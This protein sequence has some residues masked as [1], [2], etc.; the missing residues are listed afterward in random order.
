MH[1]N[2]CH[3]SRAPVYCHGEA[4]C[5]KILK[6]L[7]WHQAQP[8]HVSRASHLA[9]LVAGLYFLDGTIFLACL[10]LKS[11]QNFHEKPLKKVPCHPAQYSLALKD[12]FFLRA[13][14]RLQKKPLKRAP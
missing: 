1:Q 5:L 14:S 2:L 3:E 12:T 4:H 9:S 10:P 13:R 11:D 8:F 6:E 7:W